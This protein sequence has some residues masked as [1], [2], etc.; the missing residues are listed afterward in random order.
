MR[1]RDF[2]LALMG[3]A[4]PLLALGGKPGGSPAAAATTHAQPAALQ[5]LAERLHRL[6]EDGLNPADYAI[7]AETAVAADPAAHAAGLMRAAS[8]ALSDLLLGR[9]R[10]PTNRPDILRDPAAIPMPR[11]QLDLLGAADPA[12]VID[13]AALAPPDA[14]LLKSELAKARAIVAAGGWPRIPGGGTL[15]PGASDAERVPALRARLAVVDPALAAAPVEGTGDLY[16]EPLAAALR[17]WQEEQGLEADGR[18]G[19]ITLT[20]LNRPAAQRVDQLRVALDMRR[21]APRPPTGRRIEVNIP[22]FRLFLLDGNRTLLRMNVVVGRPDRATPLLRVS[23]TTVQFNPPW[24]VPARNAREDLLP[25]FRRD[26]K[27]MVAKGFRLF[28]TIGG[29][30][31]EVDPT[32][33]DWAHVRPDNFPYSVRQDAGDSSA[34]GRLKF[35]M[36]NND[37]IYLHDTPDRWA[38]NRPDRAF[39][40]G[41]IRL[42]RPMEL[43]DL[44]M[45]G[46]GWDRERMQRTFDTRQT[47]N[48][49]LKRSIP[50]RL[51]YTTAVVEEG[52]LRLRPD[53]YGLDAAYAREMDRGAPRVAAAR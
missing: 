51:V 42:E 36:P 16:D 26:P 49:P 24:G 13:R 39:S 48:V 8:A 9:L 27:A 44:A 34:L 3:S 28:T 52:R 14:A 45:D 4:M 23:M 33:V 25:K 50:V 10:L 15:D 38:F 2:S 19:P 7:P 21:A 40:S 47:I 12:S 20:Q 46:M 6:E 29:E 37:D 1:R 53:I 11:W 32:T 31:V 18:L 22:D 30:R 35:I 43:L 41:C 5:R 17:R